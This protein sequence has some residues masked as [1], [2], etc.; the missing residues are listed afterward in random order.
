MLYA[1]TICSH[2]RHLLREI[3]RRRR[4]RRLVARVEL[5][6]E[7]SAPSSPSRRRA[8]AGVARP[9]PSAACSRCRAR[10]ASARPSSSR[11]A[12]A[13][14][15]RERRTPRDRRG[16][17][18][19]WRRDRQP[20]ARRRDRPRRVR[21]ASGLSREPAGLWIHAAL[22][23]VGRRGLGEAVEGSSVGKSRAECAGGP[24]EPK[25]DQA[26]GRPGRIPLVSRP[27]ETRLMLGRLRLVR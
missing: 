4:A 7:A 6:A 1:R 21:L 13:R 11:A 10:R 26:K 14:G 25:D 20:R 17:G 19:R 24:R 8:C 2:A 18:R 23:S 22:V 12:A 9:R 5:V 3:R 15:R 27:S 16:R